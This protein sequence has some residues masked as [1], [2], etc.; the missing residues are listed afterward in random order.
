MNSNLK[1]LPYEGDPF[2]R[3]IKL[4]DIGWYKFGIIYLGG[5]TN[6]YRNI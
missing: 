5:E 1:F 3:C 6:G 4:I 2:E